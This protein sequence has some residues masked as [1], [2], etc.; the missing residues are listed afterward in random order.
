D[1][2]ARSTIEVLRHNGVEVE[3][4]TR[5]S[6]DLPRNLRGRFTAAASAV[7][8]PGSVRDFAALLDPFKP[9]VGHAIEVFPLVSA[10]IL[11]LWSQ[12]GGSVVMSCVD[13]RMTCPIVTHLYEGEI[14]IKC[15]GGREYWAVLKNCRNNIPESITVAVYNVI[16]RK[17]KLFRNHV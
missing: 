3:V 16:V 5:N 8:A 15:T 4:F 7:Y 6:E 11:P 14:C 12:R 13:N 17:L 9:N 2:S 1:N 10:W